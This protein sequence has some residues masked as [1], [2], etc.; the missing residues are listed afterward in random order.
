MTIIQTSALVIASLCLTACQTPN[1]PSAAVSD[2]TAMTGSVEAVRDG[3]T[4]L[5]PGQSLSVALSSNGS[6]G[7]SWSVAP[8]DEAV[9]TR[10]EPFGQE[11][12]ETHPAGMV[13]VG[14]QTHWRFTASAP[15]ETTLTFAYG[16]PWEKNAAPAQTAHYTII[17]R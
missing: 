2:T 5:R 13:G 11:R 9:L 15:G 17:V 8:F 1:A 6:T 14:G 3:V 12:T 16:R 10:S 7:F 4:R